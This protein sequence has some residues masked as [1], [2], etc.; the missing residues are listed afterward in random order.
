MVGSFSIEYPLSLLAQRLILPIPRTF[1]RRATKNDPMLHAAAVAVT[2]IACRFQV[3]S[4]PLQG[5]FYVGFRRFYVGFTSV[6]CRFYVGFSSGACDSY[7][8]R[9]HL[10][11][12]AAATCAPPP[13]PRLRQSCAACTA[14]HAARPR[15]IPP[16]PHSPSEGL[17]QAGQYLARIT[18]QCVDFACVRLLGEV[19]L[20]DGCTALGGGTCSWVMA[21]SGFP[22]FGGSP[23]CRGCEDFSRHHQ[24]NT[25]C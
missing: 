3:D 17:S 23:L 8:A 24:A 16:L 5:R 2:S 19:Y 10:S 13:L 22:Q 9:P 4:G 6:L 12:S 1:S 20:W 21:R 7:F 18:G 14:P 15:L 25:E 11:I